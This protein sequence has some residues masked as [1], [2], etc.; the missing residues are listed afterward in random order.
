M[1]KYAACGI[2]RDE[3]H[4]IK[5]WIEATKD[6][7]Y[8]IIFDSGSKDN[9]IELLK[10]E[11][12][13]LIEKHIVY[14]NYR[15]DKARNYILENL[16][17]DVDWLFWPDMDEIYEPNWREEMEKTLKQHP[18]TTRILHESY[19]YNNKK[20]KTSSENGT[21]V[22]SKIHKV[23]YY[24]WIEPVHEYMQ[25]IHP[26]DTEEIITNLNIVR[27]HYHIDIPRRLEQ[28]FIIAKTAADKN[29]DS[30]WTIWFALSES[31]KRQL[32]D[33]VIKYGNMYLNVTKPYTDFRSLAHMFIAIASMQLHGADQS[34]VISLLRSI[35]EDPG[36]ERAKLLYTNITGNPI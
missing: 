29:P 7:D 32:A 10:Q 21:Q 8:R 25:Y 35:A 12:V 13:I 24:N 23:G 1:T 2:C 26:T 31:Y 30:D 27:H 17:D 20:L 19:H 5:Q 28:S 22:D 33:D 14:L 4:N 3:E 16:P 34:V 15:F 6:F 18:N 36:N 11:D 9:T